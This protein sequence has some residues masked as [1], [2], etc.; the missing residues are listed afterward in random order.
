MT[1][2]SPLTELDI[3]LADSG[4]YKGF[5]NIVA[6]ASKILIAL[7][8][9]WAVIDPESAGKILGDIKNWSFANLN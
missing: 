6:L 1:V 3:N 4:F 5:N 8:V 7:I 9:I 2:S